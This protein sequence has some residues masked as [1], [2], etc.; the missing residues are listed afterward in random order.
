MREIPIAE[1]PT[2]E[3]P[4][5]IDTKPN[6][7]DD[8]ISILD[9]MN[10]KGDY[11]MISSKTAYQV[12]GKRIVFDIDDK[13]K[14]NVKVFLIKRASMDEITNISSQIKNE[15]CIIAVGGGSVIDVSKMVSFYTK[16]P[17]IAVPTVPSHDGI[18]SIRASIEKDGIKQSFTSSMP[19]AVIGDLNVLSNSP[20]IFTIS[21]AADLLTNLTAVLDWKLATR[22]RGEDLNMYSATLANLSA[23]SIVTYRTQISRNR[24]IAVEVVFKGLMASSLSMAIAG[25]SRPASGAEHL[26]SHKLDRLLNYQNMHGLQCGLA[27]ILTM[28]L[29]GGDWELIRETLRIIGAP[30][31]LKELNIDYDIFLQ[32]V[33]NAHKLRPERYTI[34]GTGLPKLAVEKAI[35]AIGLDS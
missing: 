15:N 5:V 13:T 17:M 4:S 27:S 23:E 3:F 18:S 28:Y 26:I 21:G 33:L 31:T 9:Y 29:H 19:I 7:I 2:I 25:T 11:I 20:K 16:I 34:L 14:Y 32:A 1:W 30:I 12:A 24:R 22:V 10:I 35:S 8:M 6:A